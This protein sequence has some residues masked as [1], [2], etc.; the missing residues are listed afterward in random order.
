MH[1]MLTFAARVLSEILT[2]RATPLACENYMS[3]GACGVCGVCDVCD[4]W[5][6]WCACQYPTA[7]CLHQTYVT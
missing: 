1:G 2:G 6:V 5:C 4:V 7:F 3:C